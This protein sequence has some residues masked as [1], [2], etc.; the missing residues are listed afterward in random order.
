MNKENS[1][2]ILP[3]REEDRNS[4]G[5]VPADISNICIPET[6]VSGDP[7]S[8][9]RS[10]AVSTLSGLRPVAWFFLGSHQV[11]LVFSVSCNF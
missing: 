7:P 3:L 9:A 5:R 11:Y 6:M 1:S 4:E 8:L 10:I 2:L